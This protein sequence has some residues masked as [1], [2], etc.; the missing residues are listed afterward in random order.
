MGSRAAFSFGG[1]GHP[2]AAECIVP[3][4][5]RK[6]K[7]IRGIFD[8]KIS[9]FVYMHKIPP[10][11]AGAIGGKIVNIPTILIQKMD[12]PPQS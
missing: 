6:Y 1:L 4:H 10:T 12:I 2:S 11:A 7:P 5:I 8:T 9:L 3:E